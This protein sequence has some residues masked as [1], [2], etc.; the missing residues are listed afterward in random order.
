MSLSCADLTS[1]SGEAC[2]CGCLTAKPSG[3]CLCLIVLPLIHCRAIGAVVGVD[4]A[5]EQEYAS[6]Y[7]IS[8]DRNTVLAVTFDRPHLHDQVLAH[9]TGLIAEGHWPAGTM[10]PAESDLAQQFKVSRTIVRECVRVLGS[11][12]MLD[13]HQGRSLYVMPHAEWKITEPLSLLVRSDRA[14]LLNW[15]EVRTLL[16]MDCA[17]LAARRATDEECHL[18]DQTINP[19]ALSED[20]PAAY[21]EIDIRFHLTI[22]KA[23]HNPALA[24]LLEAVIQPL[25]EQLDER[26][27]TSQTRHASTEEHRAIA[28]C[29]RDGDAAGTRAAMAAHLGRVADEIRQ[30]LREEISESADSV[31]FTPR[32]TGTHIAGTPERSA[33]QS[34]AETATQRGSTNR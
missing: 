18:L 22:A 26:A 3:G 2:R 25:R 31:L 13:V 21:R 14:S 17:D 4:K 28:A 15:L 1:N 6:T 30:V 5:Q 7:M 19:L 16:E 12:G 8:S 11:R 34:R 9:M 20:D 10:L 24:R 32:V 23:T 33:V 29:M 27:L